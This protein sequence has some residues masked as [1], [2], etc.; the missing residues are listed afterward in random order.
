MKLVAD[1]TDSLSFRQIPVRITDKSCLKDC[2]S[3]SVWV[4]VCFSSRL[5]LLWIHPLQKKTSEAEA[6]MPKLNFEEK[7]HSLYCEVKG[8][9]NKQTCTALANMSN[10]H[11]ERFTPSRFS[12]FTQSLQIMMIQWRFAERKSAMLRLIVSFCTG[13]RSVKCVHCCNCLCTVEMLMCM[14]CVD[15]QYVTETTVILQVVYIK[16]K[17][18]LSQRWI[19]L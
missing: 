1:M 11:W 3:S 15:I 5:Q 17:T 6:H 19:L 13:E 8:T 7:G 2:V 14:V 9:S 18:L 16:K 4:K 10:I 12:V